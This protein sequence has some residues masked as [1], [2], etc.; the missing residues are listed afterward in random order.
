MIFIYYSKQ[1]KNIYN[2]FNKNQLL[3]LRSEELRENPD[4][5]LMAVADFLSIPP[6]NP[7]DHR[8]INSRSYPHK[9]SKDELTLLKGFYEEEFSSLENILGWD[10]SSWSK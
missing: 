9:M 10:L 3:I 1:I 7:V 6:F 4:R 8:E 2:Y 5:T